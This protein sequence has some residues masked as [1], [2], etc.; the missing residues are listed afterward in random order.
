MCPL[1][2]GVRWDRSCRRHRG[3]GSSPERAVL[4]TAVPFM[5]AV[6]FLT[7]GLSGASAVT[8]V[9]QFLMQRRHPRFRMLQQQLNRL[10]ILE[11]RRWRHRLFFVEF[12]VEF[13]HRNRLWFDRQ[14]IGNQRF[15]LSHSLVPARPLPAR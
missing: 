10:P 14:N 6:S 4:S 9:E 13:K 1:M 11:S 15:Q 3:L 12:S 8:F 2:D 5:R 7:V